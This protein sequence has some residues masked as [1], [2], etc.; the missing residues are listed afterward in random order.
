M[1][2]IV[3]WGLFVVTE[4]YH[5]YEHLLKTPAKKQPTLTESFNHC[6]SRKGFGGQLLRITLHNTKDMV[7]VYT[8]E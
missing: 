8:V 2:I 4:L 1:Y 5:W 6:V 3:F 7:P